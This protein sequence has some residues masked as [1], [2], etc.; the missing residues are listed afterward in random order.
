M[1]STDPGSALYQGE[2]SQA[3]QTRVQHG[4]K[5][6]DFSRAEKPLKMAWALAPEAILQIPSGTT[7]WEIAENDETDKYGCGPPNDASCHV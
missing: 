4:L 5:G 3:V 1:R 6:H 7:N 2:T